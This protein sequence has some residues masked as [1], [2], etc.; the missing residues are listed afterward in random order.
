MLEKVLINKYKKYVWAKFK[1]IS[2][3]EFLPA[4][5]LR[6]VVLQASCRAKIFRKWP[7]CKKASCL[8]DIFAV[9]SFVY[10]IIWDNSLIMRE[11][12]QI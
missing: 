3:A 10:L 2:F 12:S 4:R 1:F 11:V 6:K 7:D 5:R 9:K 8:N